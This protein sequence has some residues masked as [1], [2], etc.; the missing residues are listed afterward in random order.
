MTLEAVADESLWIWHA[1]F[2]MPGC[3]NDINVV[4]ASPLSEKI[5]NGTYAPPVEYLING[6]RINKPYWLCD[7]IY[8]KWLVFSETIKSPATQKQNLFAK[9]QEAARKDI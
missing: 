7:G 4:E 3:L 1:F 9:L 2:G 6:I 8:R 5:S